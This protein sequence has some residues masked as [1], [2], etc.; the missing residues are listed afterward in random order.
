VGTTVWLVVIA[1][2]DYNCNVGVSVSK[3]TLDGYQC[4]TSA[5]VQVHN[6]TFG[7]IS[8]TVI[9]LLATTTPRKSLSEH[10]TREMNNFKLNLK[11]IEWTPAYWLL[12]SGFIPAM[13][14]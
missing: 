2:A 5:F 9:A 12:S 13:L 11:W 4:P 7:L 1:F 8:A 10:V 6:V 14:P 3:V